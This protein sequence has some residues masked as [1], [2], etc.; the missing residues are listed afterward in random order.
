MFGKLEFVEQRYEEINQKLS[1]PEVI[2][3]QEDWRKLMKEHSDMQDI[4]DKYREYKKVKM[5]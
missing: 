4:V 2:S 3:N 1:D 5:I